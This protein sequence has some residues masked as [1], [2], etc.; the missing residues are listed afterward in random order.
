MVVIATSATL[1]GVALAVP[2]GLVGVLRRLHGA[3][4]LAPPTEAMAEEEDASACALFRHIP[5]LAPLLAWRSLGALRETP[6]HECTLCSPLS[7]EEIRLS[8]KRED[9]ISDLYGGNKVRVSWR[10]EHRRQHPIPTRTPFILRSP[11]CEC[12]STSSRRRTHCAAPSPLKAAA[13][14]ALALLPDPLSCEQVRTLQHQLATCESRAA[15]ATTERE[16]AKRASLLVIGSGGSNQV[17]LVP[18]LAAGRCSDA[19]AIKLPSVP[20]LIRP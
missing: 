3:V 12:C 10:D 8:V 2:L 9:L 14:N 11:C 13:S 6:V 20:L 16:R 15:S 17:R 19:P 5:A 7:G 1:A 4:G 18:S